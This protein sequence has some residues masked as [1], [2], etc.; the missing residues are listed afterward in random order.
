MTRRMANM[1]LVSTISQV[2]C[3]HEAVGSGLTPP[4]IVGG[5]HD[6]VVNFKVDFDLVNERNSLLEKTTHIEEVELGA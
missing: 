3:F 1:A 5:V 6:H 4:A 2:S